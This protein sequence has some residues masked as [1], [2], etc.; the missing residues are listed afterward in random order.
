MFTAA[1]CNT[2]RPAASVSGTVKYNGK[3]QTVGYVNFLS[4]TGS[5]AQIPLDENGGYKFDGPLDV[6]EYKVYLG[7]PIPGHTPPGTKPAPAGKF[8]VTQKFLDPNSSGVKVTLKEGA[9][10]IP[11]EFKD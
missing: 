9:N 2:K 11:I 4:A 10:E 1:G 8:N 5:A 6:G 7:A 3:P